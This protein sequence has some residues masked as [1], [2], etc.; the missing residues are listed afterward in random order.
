[1]MPPIV[2]QH[3]ESISIS[4][5]L[6]AGQRH[7]TSFVASPFNFDGI[8]RSHRRVPGPLSRRTGSRGRATP[9]LKGISDSR[10][11]ALPRPDLATAQKYV[12]RQLEMDVDIDSTTHAAA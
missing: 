3:D 4:H 8:E 10:V 2:P 7:K 11:Y 1:M 9:H 5:D 6:R 12:R